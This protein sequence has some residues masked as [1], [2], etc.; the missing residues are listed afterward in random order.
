M[1]IF[2]TGFVLGSVAL[3]GFADLPGWGS[4]ALVSLPT[5]ALLHLPGAWLR[6]GIAAV[7]VAAGF[8]WTLAVAGLHQA[9]M[10]P[11]GFEG[12][13][14]KAVI[15]VASI[16]V[17]TGYS[18][19]FDAEV[20]ELGRPF[21]KWVP[22]RRIRLSL[23]PRNNRS[24]RPALRPGDL[25]DATLRLKR[26]HGYMNPGGFD[27]ERYL[28]SQRVGAT[29]Y[30]RGFELLE[31]GG[32]WSLPVLRHHL[33]ERLKSRATP[34]IGAV[35]ALA[36]GERGL[37]DKAHRDLLF[38]TGTGHLF[39]ISGLHIALIF[40]FIFLISRF[41][42]S[43]FFLR[44]SLW[45]SARAATVP[46]LLAACVY[47]WLAGFTIPTQ[48]ALIMLGCVVAGVLLRRRVSLGN[49]LP[50]ALLAVIAYDP[51][52]TLSVSFW[53]S[54]VAVGFIALY[55][56]LHPWPKKRAWLDLQTALPLALLPAGLW[57][58]GY[59][60]LVAPAANLAAV[61]LVSLLILP[62]VLLATLWAPLNAALCSFFIR[63]ADFLLGLLWRGG[64]WL[65][66]V[67]FLQWFH[68]PPAWS[69]PFA[70]A[71]IVAVTLA[72]GWRRK[73]AAA[74]LLL[75]LLASAGR[76][77]PGGAFEVAFLDVGQGLSVVVA[78]RGHTLLFDTG[79]AYRSGFTTAEAVI[80]P[81]LH[82]RGVRHLDALIVSH[83]DSDHAGGVDVVAGRFE[84]GRRLVGGGAQRGR[85]LE[86]CRDGQAWSWDG[87]HFEI[88]HPADNRGLQGNDSSCVLKVTAR[89]H[90]LLLTADIESQAEA[91]L[92]VRARERLAASVMLVPHHGSLTSSTG[93][94]V[95]AV[96]PDIAVVT[97]GYR[98]RFGLPKKE[99][100]NRYLDACA[101]VFNTAETGALLMS[102]VPGRE[103]EAPYLHRRD[104]RRYWHRHF[105]PYS[106]KDC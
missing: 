76:G 41:L 45:P 74:A 40:G 1:P 75:P 54:F 106:L 44:H 4:A 102:F 5:L 53:L 39:A 65:V 52:S 29:G 50:L 9:T 20:V 23:Y 15:R 30:V 97:S 16:P 64:D 83:G 17:D 49:T 69:Y 12:R 58:F 103:A 81:Y 34:N 13:N 63:C 31:R 8:L 99:I 66:R 67:D 87:V 88:L 7:A 91:S 43:R 60:A 35:I 18:L 14:V 51:L 38:V 6:F 37:M 25:L 85:S 89:E 95:A 46:A 19:R 78:T 48:R 84:I 104:A 3:H 11:A 33:Y 61:P 32:T 73:T 86:P 62:C 96:N 94:F 57:F 71:G 100:V 77:L 93:A 26:P 55:F 68:H 80:I 47:A 21:R 79:P 82:R 56:S 101:R 2:A 105:K 70:V 72:S 98:N 90:S 22:P 28:F 59:G 24:S 10:L 92:L 42:W 36:L 27:Y